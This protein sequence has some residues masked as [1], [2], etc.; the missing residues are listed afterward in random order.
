M[1]R[2]AWLENLIV[3]ARDATPEGGTIDVEADQIVVGPREARR[4]PE[5]P[6]G[7][8]ARIVIRDTGVGIDPEMQRHVFEP[9]FSTKD[10][11]KGTGLGLPSSTALQRKQAGR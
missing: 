3:N 2:A 11:A 9:F 5:V 6:K 10:P 4:Y 1:R 8:Y 7:R